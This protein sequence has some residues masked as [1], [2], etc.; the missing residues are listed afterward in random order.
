VSPKI[1]PMASWILAQAG[2]K[3]IDLAQTLCKSTWQTTLRDCLNIGYEPLRLFRV[4]AASA[5]FALGHPA[6]A[7]QHHEHIERRAL[8]GCRGY[9]RHWKKVLSRG[10]VGILRH[11]KLR[12]LNHAIQRQASV[13]RMAP[14][15]LP[16]ESIAAAIP[17]MS[18]ACAAGGVGGELHGVRQWFSASSG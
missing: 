4:L 15:I 10:L 7:R 9:R 14:A 1:P 16:R 12:P 13:P 17:N 6:A 8:R 3:H 2:Q 18:R 11:V 5:H